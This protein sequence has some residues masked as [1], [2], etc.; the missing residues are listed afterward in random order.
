MLVVRVRNV[1]K[2]AVN[3]EYL[4]QYLL[5]KSPIVMDAEG[6]RA[7]VGNFIDFLGMHIP[8]KVTLAPGKEI[9]IH[10]LKLRPVKAKEAGLFRPDVVQSENDPGEE[11]W[12][13]GKVNVQYEQ[14]I[15]NSSSG[16]MKLDPNL[17][18]LGTG[19]L[20]LEVKSDPP[21]KQEQ[22]QGKEI[23]T[24][25]G[26]EVGGLQAG[27][28]LPSEKRVYHH[29]ETVTLVVRLRNVGK[30]TVKFKYIRQFLDEKPP[31]VTDADGKTVPQSGTTFLGFHVPAEVSLEPGKEIQLES[32]LPLRYELRPASG[33]GNPATKERPL[34]VGTGKVGIQF[35]QVFGNSSSGRMEL[36]P[37]LTKLGTGKL[38]LEI[39]SE[40]PA[41][42]EK[43]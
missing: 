30:E 20:E 39:K 18:K 2:E 3:F 22:K 4:R 29:G 25:W 36:D 16:R 31:T 5:E 24:A 34:L 40:P 28:S 12:A 42:T 17:A 1:G 8:V 23:V 11:F 43:K 7:N 37:T 13:T 14:V 35:E 10:E 19:K 9:E 15:G 32:R 27:L 21:K 6:K 41:G 26:K 33:G 38:E